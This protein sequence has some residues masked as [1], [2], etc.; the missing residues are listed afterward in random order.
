MMRASATEGL[1]TPVLL[2]AVLMM[3]SCCNTRVWATTRAC[4]LVAICASARTTSI[5]ARVPTS[6]CLLLSSSSFCEAARASCATRTALLNATRSQYNS[7][8]AATVVTTW[9]W[10]VRSA[11]SRLFLAMRIW[12]EFTPP[13]PCNRC[14]EIVKDRE[15]LVA[16]LKSPRRLLFVTV[17]LLRPRLM[18]APRSGVH[19]PETLQQM[20]R[21]SEGQGATRGRVEVPAQAVV[22]D[23]VVAQAQ[24]HGCAGQKPLLNAQTVRVLPRD[25][26]VRAGGERAAL[27]R[28]GVRPT[29]VAH[30]HRIE[31]RNG[32]PGDRKSTR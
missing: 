14:C 2:S 25:Q 7:I 9:S 28:G 15:P 8:T 23:G 30:Q 3:V 19:P 31:A 26:E 13:K 10:T 5:C 11:T 20:L 12:R 27:R 29:H 24:T 18:V 22:R 16:G 6:T 4:S 1:A 21:N 32:G 17:L